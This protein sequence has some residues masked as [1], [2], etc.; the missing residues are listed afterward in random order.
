MTDPFGAQLT[1][2]GRP[3][4]ARDDLSETFEESAAP[5]V[6]D[7]AGETR[8]QVP[9]PTG[10]GLAA[11]QVGDPA[12]ALGMAV[13]YLMSK[14]AFAR[15]PFGHWARVLIGQI[16]RRHYLFVAR[17]KTLV[18]FA[19][20]AFTTR[21]KA[22]SWIAGV[23]DPSFED[24]KE[25]EIIVINAWE[26]STPEV[27]HFLVDAM[28]KIGQAKEMIYFK[29]FY[30]DGRVRPVRLKVNEFVTKHVAQKGKAAGG[31]KLRG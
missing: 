4:G 30:N 26:A 22:E 17:G 21:D 24:S 14:P 15:L 28:R 11:I 29:R 18:G 1:C 16:N 8:K 31:S 9:R 3:G 20:W 2:E 13:S 7:D 5:T 19:G 6:Q 25:G 27:H 10:T 12:R 23:S